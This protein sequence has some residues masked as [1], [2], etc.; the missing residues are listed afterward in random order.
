MSMLRQRFELR[1]SLVNVTAA[2]ISRRTSSC[3]AQHP[4]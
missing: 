4:A 3:M 2:N 1:L